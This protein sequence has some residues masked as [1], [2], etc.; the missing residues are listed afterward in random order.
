MSPFSIS[1]QQLQVRQSSISVSN[2]VSFTLSDCTWTPLLHS[3]VAL[4]ETINTKCA[5]FFYGRFKLLSKLFSLFPTQLIYHLIFLHW[6]ASSERLLNKCSIISI[7]SDSEWNR[8][9]SVGKS[10]HKMWNC[11]FAWVKNWVKITPNVW[12]ILFSVALGVCQ[13]TKCFPRILERSRENSRGHWQRRMAAHRR[14]WEVASCKRNR[15]SA[16]IM[17]I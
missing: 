13:R 8:N 16:N 5:A 2:I 4:C 3:W 12:F 1:E 17:L 9:M 10:K 14:H 7:W 6:S 15:L 11:A